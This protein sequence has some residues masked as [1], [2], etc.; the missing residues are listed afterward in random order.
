MSHKVLQNPF[1]QHYRNKIFLKIYWQW[2]DVSCNGMIMKSNYARISRN[3]R[4]RNTPKI[5]D[6]RLS[7]NMLKIL[8]SEIPKRRIYKSKYKKELDTQTGEE[9]EA[10]KNVEK[11][12]RGRKFEWVQFCFK[13]LAHTKCKHKS[14]PNHWFQTLT[15]PIS[16]SSFGTLKQ[17]VPNPN[18][19]TIKETKHTKPESRMPN[20][21][22]YKSE[23][24]RPLT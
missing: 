13:N 10:W 3:F 7:M 2:H 16:K 5:T 8:T 22:S 18:S 11:S 19:I 14:Q 12:D 1:Q 6:F 4:I 24:R 23:E 21:S 9:I 17:P 20:P 15:K